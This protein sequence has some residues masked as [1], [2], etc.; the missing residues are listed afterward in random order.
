MI[1]NLLAL[2][3]KI[4]CQSNS[5]FIVR[6]ILCIVGKFSPLGSLFLIHTKIARFKEVRVNFVF[7]P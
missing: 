5:L 2:T 3:V 6:I 4:R 1:I 7:L